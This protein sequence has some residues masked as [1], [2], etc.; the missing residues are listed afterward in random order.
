MKLA[1]G[2]W[3]SPDQAAGDQHA[4]GHVHLAGGARVA[5]FRDVAQHSQRS[6]YGKHWSTTRRLLAVLGA[7][8]RG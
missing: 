6:P 5:G 2:A 1:P 7:T 4:P 8:G 3:I